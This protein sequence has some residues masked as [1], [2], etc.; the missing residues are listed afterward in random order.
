MRLCIK[1]G[2]AKVVYN[3]NIVDDVDDYYLGVTEFQNAQIFWNDT[4]YLHLHT[5]HCQNVSSCLEY[6]L[7]QKININV[8]SLILPSISIFSFF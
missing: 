6:V 4:Y 5:E 2:L 3:T 1:G 8:N 7:A